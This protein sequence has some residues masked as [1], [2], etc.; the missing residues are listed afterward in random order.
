MTYHSDYDTYGFRK[1][2]ILPLL[3]KHGIALDIGHVEQR[4]SAQA[5]SAQMPGWKLVL[6]RRKRLSIF[7]A[8]CSLVGIDPFTEYETVER[9]GPNEAAYDMNKTLLDEAIDSGL[10]QSF[11]RTEGNF[12]QS[13]IAVRDFAA[14]CDDLKL[15]W[16]LP[17]S[18]DKTTTST[19]A[20]LQREVTELRQQLAQATEKNKQ[21]L[22]ENNKLFVD[23]V[24]SDD[25]VRKEAKA[26]AAIYG[27]RIKS[28]QDKITRLQSE[29][30][31]ARANQPAT[32]TPVPGYLDPAHPRYSH[33]LAAAVQAWEA[34]TEPGNRGV[35]NAI[36][37]WLR[38]HARDLRLMNQDKPSTK[39]IADVATVVN[40]NVS[41]GAPKT[42]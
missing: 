7:E 41:G 4:S 14:W 21:L 27:E 38:E 2:E 22:S 35:K 6:A 11:E 18:F 33:R 26:E 19:D 8:V 25:A 16:P 28:L 24:E 36:E 42:Y 34:V 31:Q 40:W 20:E 3:A 13:F 10:I 17:W 32:T 39:A 23:S 29:L 30:E 9:H 12:T 5:I 1:D 15:D 37:V